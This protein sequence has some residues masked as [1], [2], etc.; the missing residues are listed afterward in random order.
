MVPM[1]MDNILGFLKKESK[2]ISM[3]TLYISMI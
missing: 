1:K 3:V 2:V